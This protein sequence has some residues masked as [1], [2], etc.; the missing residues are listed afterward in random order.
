VQEEAGLYWGLIVKPNL[1]FLNL[2]ITLAGCCK[3]ENGGVAMYAFIG[4]VISS[5]TS[6]RNGLSGMSF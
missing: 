6:L 4:P 1:L 5:N 2:W 3:R